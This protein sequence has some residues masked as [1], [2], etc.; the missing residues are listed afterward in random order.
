MSFGGALPRVRGAVNG[1]VLVI[2]GAWGALVP[3]VGPIVHLAYTPDLAWTYTTGRLWLSVIPGAATVIAGLGV[4]GVASR[5]AGVFW[6]W[7][8]AAAG[9]WFVIGPSISTLWTDGRG[10]TGL[11]TGTTIAGRALEEVVFFYGLGAAIVFIAGIALG[12]FT[13][14]TKESPKNSHSA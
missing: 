9:T 6:G 5:I 12:R 7:L 4:L 10:D 13:I 14:G 2:L 11:P 1:L 3:F 8:A